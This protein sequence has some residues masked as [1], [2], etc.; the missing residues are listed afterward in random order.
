LREEQ[1][2]DVVPLFSFAENLV[3]QLAKNVGGI[4]QPTRA[5]PGG[6]SFD[7][8]QLTQE[9][10]AQIPLQAPRPL[11]VRASFQDEK[12]PW[13]QLGLGRRVNEQLRDASAGG[14]NAPFVFVD[15]EEFP[16]A[17]AVGGRYRV[18]DKQVVVNVILVRDEKEL[19]QFQVTAATADLAGLAAQIVRQTETR[20]AQ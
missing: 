19:A 18:E 15:A 6:Q 2:V 3:P 16:G 4:Q 17:C 12:R 8:G 7:I 20:L 9:D 5:N 14:R 1:F 13:D 11:V 10:K